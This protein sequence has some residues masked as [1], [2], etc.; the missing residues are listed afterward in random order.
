MSSHDYENILGHCIDSLK[1]CKDLSDKYL[2]NDTEIFSLI[3]DLAKEYSEANFSKEKSDRAILR[4]EKDLNRIDNI[5]LDIEA[6]HKKYI[7]EDETELILT[8]SAV[9][10]DVF[11]G[12]DIQEILQENETLSDANFE[13]VDDSLLCSNVFQPPIDPIS[14][15]LIKEPYKNAVCG[16][17]FDYDTIMNYVKE[18]KGKTK[19]P[20]MGCANVAFRASHLKLDERMK[21]QV[22]LY[23][24]QHNESTEEE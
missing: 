24:Q 6:L 3:K 16:H 7:D 8:E 18:K 5:D 22:L 11:S 17:Y 13:R 14:K 19:C 4:I 2:K 1:S 10:K 23:L 12:S 9:W 15:V 20:Y 21:K